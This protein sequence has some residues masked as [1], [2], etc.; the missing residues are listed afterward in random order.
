[1]PPLYK[2]ETNRQDVHVCLDDKVFCMEEVRRGCEGKDD[3]RPHLVS[4]SEGR[5]PPINDLQRRLLPAALPRVG[6]S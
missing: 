5:L 2:I 6:K 4:G 1:M 3:S